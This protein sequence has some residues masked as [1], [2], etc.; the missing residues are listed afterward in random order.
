MLNLFK[1][2]KIAIYASLTGRTIALEKVSDPV[3]SQ[4]IMGD[5]F[6]IEPESQEIYAPISG[7]IESIFPTK[8]AL[9]I[10]HQG[11]KV[12]IHIGID[13]VEL[14]GKG[15]DLKVKAGDKVR[16]DTLLANV[17]FDYL[18]SQGKAATTMILFPELSEKYTLTCQFGRFTA[19]EIVGEIEG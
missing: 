18:I 4:K 8:H 11:V 7:I 1:K 15:F 19:Q 17:D 14:A 9:I 16:S 13:T 6:A 5:G 10:D 3:F 2:K 12:L